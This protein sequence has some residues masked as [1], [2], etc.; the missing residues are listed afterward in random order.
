MAALQYNVP[1]ETRPF[2]VPYYS[3]NAYLNAWD[4]GGT[5]YVFANGRKT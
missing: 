2:C 4:V 5:W 1:W 3:P